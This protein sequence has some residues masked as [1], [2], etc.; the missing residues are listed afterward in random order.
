LG[1]PS[2]ISLGTLDATYVL[3][4]LPSVQVADA[5]TSMV[6]DS[7]KKIFSMGNLL[8]KV[9]FKVYND[10]CDQEI[11]VLVDMQTSLNDRNI[12]VFDLKFQPLKV[13]DPSCDDTNSDEVRI[14][15][16][17]EKRELSLCKRLAFRLFNNDLCLRL[18]DLIFGMKGIHFIPVIEFSSSFPDVPNPKYTFNAVNE[19]TVD[20]C[21]KTTDCSTCNK[22]SKC[23]WCN[24]RR[25]CVSREAELDN[26]GGCLAGFS[27]K[28]GDDLILET[29]QCSSFPS[30]DA[31]SNWRLSPKEWDDSVGSWLTKSRSKRAFDKMDQNGDNIIEYQEYCNVQKSKADSK[32]FAPGWIALIV[33][34]VVVALLVAFLVALLF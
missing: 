3:G 9:C 16:D 10:F 29:Q 34:V 1:I 19:G 32:G 23:G 14:L 25:S 7:I 24:S 21:F 17:F 6:D 15:Y 18:T 22:N 31:D 2:T 13:F 33:I 27:E 20:T 5:A 30:F 12:K 28:C 26:C 4:F 8:G 11:G